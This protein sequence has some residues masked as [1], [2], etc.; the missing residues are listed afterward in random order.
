MVCAPVRSIIPSL[1][2]GD[3]LSVQAHKPCF[4]S[5]LT[6]AHSTLLFSV[7]HRRILYQTF[8]LSN[9]IVITNEE[10]RQQSKKQTTKSKIKYKYSISF[11]LLFRSGNSLLKACYFAR[12]IGFEFCQRLFC[13]A[14]HGGSTAVILLSS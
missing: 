4:I 10:Q 9:R 3:Y 6:E 12:S 13:T 2:L 7:K 1:K 14:R 5:H 11:S 8:Q